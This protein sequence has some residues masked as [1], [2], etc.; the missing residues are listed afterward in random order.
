MA[1]GRAYSEDEDRP[2]GARLV[3]LSNGLWRRRFAADP[4]IVGRNIE[5]D[6]EPYLVTGV[7]AATF[8]SDPPADIYMPL[9]ADPNSTD[10]AHY[11]RSAARMK[12]GV[13]LAQ[14]QAAMKLAAD[15]I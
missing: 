8:T 15:D 11:L 10:Q 9:Q 3:V 5:L 1:A 12:P 14:V 2:G 6:G 13:T 4:N 7:L